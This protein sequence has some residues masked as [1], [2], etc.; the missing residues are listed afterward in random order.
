MQDILGLFLQVFR[1]LENANS[2]S[3][4]LCLSVLDTVSQV[5]QMIEHCLDHFSLFIRG[6]PMN[7]EWG[8]CRV[9]FH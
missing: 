6:N 5:G 9:L 2:P 8:A 4:Q 3:F 1:R 7:E